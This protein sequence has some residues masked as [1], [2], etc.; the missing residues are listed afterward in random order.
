M[1]RSYRRGKPNWQWG[2]SVSRCVASRIAVEM[3][4]HGETRPIA[5]SGLHQLQTKEPPFFL[6]TQT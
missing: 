6:D 4:A 5:E 2:G 3:V 1:L